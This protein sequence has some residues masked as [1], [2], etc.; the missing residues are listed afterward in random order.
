VKLRTPIWAGANII[1]DY[2][3]QQLISYPAKDR[4]Q[5]DYQ[6]VFFLF[7]S[8]VKISPKENFGGNAPNIYA[9][10]IVNRRSGR[11]GMTG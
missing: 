4:T 1:L 8:L 6:G 5:K 11:I 9:R 10:I 7:G 3:T 2:S